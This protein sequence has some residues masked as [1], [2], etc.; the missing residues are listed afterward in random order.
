M[1]AGAR[2]VGDVAAYRRMGSHRDE[3]PVGSVGALLSRAGL[4]GGWVWLPESLLCLDLEVNCML[5]CY[6]G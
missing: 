5:L 3:G 1:P 4:V 2:E 6:C